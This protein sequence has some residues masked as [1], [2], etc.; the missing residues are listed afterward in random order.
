MAEVAKPVQ[1]RDSRYPRYPVGCRT[2]RITARGTINGVE[3]I[4]VL[5]P[6]ATGRY[7]KVTL[8]PIGRPARRTLE[9]AAFLG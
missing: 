1:R 3:H 6:D 9:P 2:S 8:A 5:E 7:Q 4:V